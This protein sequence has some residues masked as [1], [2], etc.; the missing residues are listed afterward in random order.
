MLRKLAVRLEAAVTAF[1][2]AL[3][4]VLLATM[5]AAVFLDAI[6]RVFAAGEGRLERLLVALLPADWAP[7]VRAVVAPAVLLLF[8]FVVVQGALR[9]R[10]PERSR[11]RALA[12]AAAITAALVVAV[13]LLLRGLPNGLVWSQQMA[14]CFLLWVGLAGASLGTRER[15]HVTFELAGKLWPRAWARWV[16]IAARA[17]AAAFTLLLAVLAAAHTREHW[18]EWRSSGGTA[19]LFEAFRVPRWAI[20][21]FL[22]LPFTAMALRFAAYGVRPEETASAG[23]AGPVAPGEA[24]R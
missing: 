19:G 3:V 18:Q 20:T 5:A 4:V 14:L 8:T 24:A 2:R 7:A 11:R 17:V 10:H 13:Q 16:E 6:H 23:A 9:T 1:E 21:G 22:P 15:A 12:A